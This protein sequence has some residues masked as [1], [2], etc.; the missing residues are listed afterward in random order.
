MPSPE[1]QAAFQH[2][3][4]SCDEGYRELFVEHMLATKLSVSSDG[5]VAENPLS[6]KIKSAMDWIQNAKELCEE[7]REKPSVLLP[8]LITRI[9][10]ALEICS[11]EFSHVRWNESASELARQK[12]DDQAFA[13]RAEWRK[14]ETVNRFTIYQPISNLKK[15]LLKDLEQANLEINQNTR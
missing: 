14:H 5:E 6:L 3:I 13:G 1:L 11:R 12:F 9:T 10:K 2:A 8:F 7:Y 4:E 15:Q